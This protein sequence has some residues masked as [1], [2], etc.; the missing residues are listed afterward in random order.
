MRMCCIRYSF[1][2]ISRFRYVCLTSN[3]LWMYS[4][5]ATFFNI[6]FGCRSSSYMPVLCSAIEKRKISTT[7]EQ[8]NGKLFFQHSITSQRFPTFFTPP[9]IS[10]HFHVKFQIP[11]LVPLFCEVLFL[12]TISLFLYL[13]IHSFTQ[14]DVLMLIFEAST[15]QIMKIVEGEPQFREV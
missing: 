1:L 6:F 14:C 15:H 5:F 10:F 9:F 12:D 3:V 13:Y 11:R 2:K 8:K 4:I 7:N